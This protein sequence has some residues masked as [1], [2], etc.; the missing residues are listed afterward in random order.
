MRHQIIQEDDDG[1]EK[2][3]GQLV[4][5]PDGPMRL[6]PRA[7][8]SAKKDKNSRSAVAQEQGNTYYIPPNLGA[9]FLSETPDSRFFSH[10]L[11]TVSTLL[12]VYDNPH[13]ANPYRLVFPSL[14]SDSYALQEAM[15]ALGALHLANTTPSSREFNLKAMALSRYS[16]CVHSLREGLS[17]NTP[18]KLAD[19]ATVLLLTF[20]EMMDSD[21][22][23]WQTH[24]KG[25]KD[26]F[27]KLFSVQTGLVAGSEKGK[28]TE[29]VRNFLISA[30][31]YLDVAAAAS[32]AQ[33]TQLSGAYWDTV[34][35]GWQYNLGVPSLNA[36]LEGRVPEDDNLSDI[37]QAWSKLMTIQSEVGLLATEIDAGAGSQACQATRDR[38]MLGLQAWRNNLP[39]IFSHLDDEQTSLYDANS[40]E[41]ASCVVCYEQATIIYFH[42]VAGTNI[43]NQLLEQ[44]VDRILQIFVT[45]GHG[46]SQ[47]GMLWALF[48]AGTE[49]GDLQRQEFVRS[50]MQN[51]LSFG[52]GN[53]K[54]ALQLLELVWL[55]RFQGGQ[56]VRWFVIQ[57][58]LQWT[59]LLP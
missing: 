36:A 8:R 50:R 38:L 51:M 55:R 19:L 6:V 18:P 4:L 37:R 47:M 24:L 10:F 3:P 52:L 30:L 58:E 57:K 9:K 39:A 22:N 28:H 35:G 42:Q 32:T 45:Y 41:G 2:I 5:I 26:L 25:A 31:A 21:T 29:A 48:I 46:V 16:R 44:S 49:T 15:H 27:E 7:P 13:N 12:I 34:G 17:K 14:A 20:F 53:V 59:L 40:I 11:S 54:R 56:D 33:T 23:N 1:D 43:G